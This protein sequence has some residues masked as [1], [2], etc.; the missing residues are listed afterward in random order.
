MVGLIFVN[1]CCCF[2][3]K[4]VYLDEMTSFLDPST[5]MIVFCFDQHYKNLYICILADH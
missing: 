4:N 5:R 3:K 2:V 1:N